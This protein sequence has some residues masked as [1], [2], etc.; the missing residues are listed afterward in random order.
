[1]STIVLTRSRP[2]FSK[3]VVACVFAGIAAL[4]FGVWTS[5][6]GTLRPRRVLPHEVHQPMFALEMLRDTERD[7][8]PEIV[9]PPRADEE[10]VPGFVPPNEPQ[11]MIKAV[12]IDF[13]FIASYGTFLVLVG[14][15]ARRSASPI[16][17][18]AIMASGLGAAVLDVRENIA[19]LNLLRNI[20]GPLARE[21]SLTKWMLL[22]IA[23]ACI[24]PTLIDRQTST[25]RRW[26]GITGALVSLATAAQG[27]YGRAQEIDLVIESAG[28]RLSLAFLFALLFMSTRRT[29]DQGLLPALD[30]LAQLPLLRQLTTWPSPD[31]NE[32]V[33]TS[34]YEP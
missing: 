2:A 12:Q 19:L 30:R 3:L 11:Q 9:R 1:M 31:I 15:L 33:G 14:W 10:A 6:A 24:A 27:L 8:L 23:A 22:F 16:L 13:G 25:F 4:V 17:A 20:P 7:R 34:V 28:S 26:L 5:R 29:L 32:T 18:F 21:A